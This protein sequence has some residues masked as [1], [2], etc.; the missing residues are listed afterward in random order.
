[1]TMLYQFPIYYRTPGGPV[2]TLYR[3]LGECPHLLIA[4]ATGSGK[5]VALNGIIYTLLTM[6]TPAHC[7][8]CLIDPKKVELI[9]YEPLPHTARYAPAQG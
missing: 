8:F 3:K 9:Q 1:M 2:F 6:K 5:S 4:G 7:R